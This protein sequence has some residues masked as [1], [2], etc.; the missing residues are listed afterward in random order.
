MTNRKRTRRDTDSSVAEADALLS[1]VLRAGH[2]DDA[3]KL[4]THFF[5]GYPID[6]L[7]QLLRSNASVVVECGA[8]IASE[9]GSRAWPLLDE[10]SALLSHESRGVRSSMIDCVS[11]CATNSHGELIAQALR[12]VRDPAWSVRKVATM[13]LQYGSEEQLSAALT[14]LVHDPLHPH[15]AWLL[16]KRSMVHEEIVAALSAPE[17]LRRLVAIASAARRAGVGREALIQFKLRDLDAVRIAVLSD[18]GDVSAFAQSVLRI[19][20]EVEAG[21]AKEGG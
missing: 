18:D 19:V 8:F 3:Y 13:M 10:F 4:L 15:L 21:R 17:P 7:R 5:R 12:L 9:L 14:F 11:A 16:S 1:S 2:G 6:Q 20:D